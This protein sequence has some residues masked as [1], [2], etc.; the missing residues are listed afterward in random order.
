MSAPVINLDI[1][2]TAR[3]AAQ[4]VETA[5][6]RGF[7]GDLDYQRGLRLIHG[8]QTTAGQLL[9]AIALEAPRGRA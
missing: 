2:R 3:A 1:R 8:G 7:G 4:A 9:A 5:A 6:R